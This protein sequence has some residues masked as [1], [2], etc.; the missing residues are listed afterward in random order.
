MPK[1]KWPV[2]AVLG[3]QPAMEAITSI[4]APLLAGFSV[5]VAILVVTSAGDLRWPAIA[6]LAAMLAAVLLIACVEF[7]AWARQYA[8]TPEDYRTWFDDADTKDGRT[9]IV[10]EMTRLRELW[11][12]WA[13]RARISYNGGITLLLVALGLTA[14]PPAGV[15]QHG[16]RWTASGVAFVAAGLEV[17]WAAMTLIDPP[18]RPLAPLW[19]LIIPTPK[20]TID[21]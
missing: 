10:D 4:A 14:A 2:P 16:L 5:T 3:E 19:K 12:V 9:V 20:E 13:G 7:A 6:M 11:E 21:A 18:P 15:A 8:A 17:I 1:P